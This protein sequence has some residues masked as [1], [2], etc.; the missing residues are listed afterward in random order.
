MGGSDPSLTQPSPNRTRGRLLE[1]AQGHLQGVSS[2]HITLRLSGALSLLRTDT[3][4]CTRHGVSQEHVPSFPSSEVALTELFLSLCRLERHHRGLLLT[5]NFAAQ[6]PG[7]KESKVEVVG[8]WSGARSFASIPQRLYSHVPSLDARSR[9]HA[10]AKADS[11][12]TRQ[13]LA[14][15]FLFFAIDQR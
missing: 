10:R 6:W 3:Q 12:C 11:L 1:L 14:T 5:E 8:S 4:N 7:T 15:T 2:L 13:T 9:L